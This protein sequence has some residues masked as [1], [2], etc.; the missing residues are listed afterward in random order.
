MAEPY[1]T[2]AWLVRT[3]RRIRFGWGEIGHLAEEAARFGRRVL[4]VCDEGIVRCGLA[5]HAA[6]LLRSGGIE[7]VLLASVEPEPSCA[8]VDRC[9]A[10]A[11]HA[12]AAAI[13]GLGGGSAID[14]AKLLAVLGDDT[15][16][17]A[18][19]VGVDRV[20]RGGLPLIAVPTTA[21]T[22]AEMTPNAV[23]SDTVASLKRGVV[24]EHLV[25]AVAIVDAELT[26]GLPPALTASTGVD[27]LAHAIEAFLS[28]KANPLSD[29]AAL[30]A[31]RLVAR[32]LREAVAN[33]RHRAAREDM[34]LASMLGGMAIATSGT[35]AVHAMSYP[36]GGMI[37]IP[38]GL[39]NAVL[40]P[41]VLGSTA[42]AAPQR[43]R[44]IAEALG[45]GTGGQTDAHAAAMAVAE[46]QRIVRDVGI[47]AGL[48][49]LGVS[50]SHLDAL[51]RAAATVTRLLENNPRPLGVDEIR[52]L[53]ER[54][55]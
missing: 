45:L 33:G 16:S 5:D 41:V 27:V 30:Q 17:V 11:R 35:T 31:I 14:T 22:G 49:G 23:V 46:I 54:A 20:A 29:L 4:L 12:G 48:R 47:P 52:S 1:T 51:S 8:A 37:G 15:A 26:V 32:S 18:D 6:A 9:A 42:E 55:L 34:M 40:L 3:P 43:F 53:Y 39:A 2:G 28:R 10:E 7:V 36:L 44:G 13:I 50:P 21:G 24:S 19:L 38:H 25:P